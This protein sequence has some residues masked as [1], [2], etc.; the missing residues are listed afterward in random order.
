MLQEFNENIWR[1][2]ILELLYK[3]GKREGIKEVVDF[4][5]KTSMDAHTLVFQVSEL[6]WQAKLKDWNISA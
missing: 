4:L 1:Q 2:Q 5:N 6:E 3:K